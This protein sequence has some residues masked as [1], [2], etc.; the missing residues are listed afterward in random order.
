[1]DTYKQI[2]FYHFILSEYGL[3]STITDSFFSSNGLKECY[4]I[5]KEYLIKYHEAPSLQQMKELVRIQ[6]KSSEITDDAL[7]SIYAGLHNVKEY[8]N[9][10][11]YDTVTAL[12]RWNQLTDALKKSISFVK[13]K[14]SQVTPENVKEICEQTKGIFNQSCVIDFDSN[15][16]SKIHSF[17]DT[18]T[19]KQVKL[20]RKSTG[21][22]FVDRCLGGGYWE[23]ALIVFAGA[24]KIGK[25]TWLCNMCKKS[26]EMGYHSAYISLEMNHEM[27]AQRIGSAMFSIPSYDYAKYASDEEY[28]KQKI[29]AYRKTCLIPPGDIDIHTFGTS[30]LSVLDLEAY[31]L[32]TEEKLSTPDNKYHFNVIYIDYINIMKNYK[33]PTSENTYLKIKTLAEDVKAMGIKNGWCIVTA[34]QTIRDNFGQNDISANQ[35][36]ESSGLGA[37]VDAMFGIIATDPMKIE[38]RYQLKCI[39]DRV[40]PEENKMKEFKIEKE[41]QRIVEDINSPVVDMNNAIRNVMNDNNFNSKYKQKSQPQQMKVVPAESSG[42]LSNNKSIEKP[43]ASK[44]LYDIGFE[45][46]NDMFRNVGNMD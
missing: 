44:I 37:T 29:A 27:V 12:A 32:S 26:S 46:S 7:D 13:L 33:N 24:P 22:S 19:H 16:N 43:Q 6:N 8:T 30:T 25:S 9:D 18:D 39:Y 42:I 31:L 1:M 14:E 36:A 23:G 11:L 35:I 45:T 17:W 40:A 3:C 4:N 20:K 38:G 28:M 34:T 2:I 5:A 21:F 41:Y 15:D 10:W